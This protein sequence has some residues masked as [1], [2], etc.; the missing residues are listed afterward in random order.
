MELN[1]INWS[2]IQYDIGSATMDFEKLKI[3]SQKVEPINLTEQFEEL[4][5]KLIEARDELYEQNSFDFSDKLDYKFDL[6]FG[7]KLYSI[8]SEEIG[9][10]QRVASNDDVWRYLSVK[11]IPDIVHARWQLNEDHFYKIPRRIWLKTLW[12]YIHLSWMGN[13]ERTYE[14][15]KNNSTDTILQLVERPGIGYYV[16]LYREL[17][18]QYSKYDD[19]SRQLF[20]KVLKLNTARLLTTSPEL[21]EGGILSYVDDLFKSI[22]E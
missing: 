20:R 3:M 15:L 6:M 1:K 8:L 21:V 9:F 12:W 22:E 10:T 18:S 14:I 13:Q 17:M 16:M 11:V 4:R 19:T 7:L 2:D 5:I